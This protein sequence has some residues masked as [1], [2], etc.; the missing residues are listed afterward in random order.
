ME[1]E[2]KI[3]KE[4]V[5]VEFPDEKK[6]DGKS[7]GKAFWI[8]DSRFKYIG[9]ILLIIWL[10]L[11]FLL[12]FK[13]NEITKDPCSICAEKIGENVICTTQGFGQLQRTYYP[14]YTFHTYPLHSASSPSY[15]QLVDIA[16]DGEGVSLGIGSL[17]GQS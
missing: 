3:D 13:A 10:T 12:F 14:N 6:P 8:T 11:F 9:L 7:K 15:N 2:I 16:T 1:D 5:S 4:K 17:T